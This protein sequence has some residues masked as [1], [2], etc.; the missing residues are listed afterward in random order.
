MAFDLKA[1]LKLDSSQFTSALKNA[2][3]QLD[4]FGDNMGKMGKGAFGKLGGMEGLVSGAES[5]VNGAKKI[6]GATVV[7]GGALVGLGKAC[8]EASAN[9][10][11]LDSQFQQVFKGLEDEA[12]KGL[13][14]TAEAT[15]LMETQMKGSFTQIASFAKTTGMDTKDALSIAE[16]SMVVAADSSAFYDRSLKDVTES[17]QSFLK[18][19]YENDA[20]L[21]LSCTETTRNAKAMELFGDE[22]KKLSEEQKQKTLLAM[23]EDANKL[24]GAL[25]QSTREAGSY[26]AQMDKLRQCFEDLKA[27]IGGKFLEPV[28]DFMTKTVEFLQTPE[29]DSFADKVGNAFST[30]GEISMNI[31]KPFIEDIKGIW[32]SMNDEDGEDSL[33]SKAIGKLKDLLDWLKEPENGETA[34]KTLR[35]MG[36][37]IGIIAGALALMNVNPMTLLI[38][39]VVGVV[40]ALTALYESCPEVKKGMDDFLEGVKNWW[41]WF[42]KVGE[43][44][45]T[46]IDLWNEWLGLDNGDDKTNGRL[47]SIGY[48]GSNQ[49][50]NESSKTAQKYREQRAKKNKKKHYENHAG[51]WSYIP[52]DGLRYLHKGE[53][54]LT[55]E[56]NKAYGKGGN[57]Y[58]I[59]LN[60]NG[61]GN[62]QTDADQLFKILVRQIKQAGGDGA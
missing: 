42:V 51:G 35:N 29:F 13:K 45:E 39:A 36:I 2:Q 28:V 15:G 12:S 25:G 30:I 31:I 19:N 17:L 53:R 50:D 1:V 60:Y 16:R 54:V 27:R 7:A 48:G 34:Y 26:T 20:A 14:K 37:A 11:A 6:A 57:T 44:I 55:P 52:S 10:Q 22:F 56:E 41:D 3:N 62:T 5:V 23:V 18:G 59:T 58:N 24:S 32:S 43:A 46:V 61:T 40:G 49:P 21:G 4:K 8:V 38:G 47:N 33:L 9:A